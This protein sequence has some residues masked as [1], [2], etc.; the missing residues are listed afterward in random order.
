MLQKKNYME[1]QSTERMR[2]KEEMMYR[3]N[4]PYLTVCGRS[5]AYITVCN[6][7]TPI[8]IPADFHKEK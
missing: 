3:A 6:G 5:G 8:E 7:V 1:Q 2:R 4:R